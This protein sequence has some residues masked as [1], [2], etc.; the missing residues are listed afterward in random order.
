MFPGVQFVIFIAYSVWLAYTGMDFLTSSCDR[1]NNKK[2]HT[3][4]PHLDH[5]Q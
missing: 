5:M 1:I 2:T 4:I 3:N